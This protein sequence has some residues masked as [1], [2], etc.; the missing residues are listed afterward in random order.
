MKQKRLRSIVFK[1]SLRKKRSI[2][3]IKRRKRNKRTRK[4]PSRRDLDRK[5]RRLRGRGV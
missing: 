4:K 3:D 2:G 5:L 1:S